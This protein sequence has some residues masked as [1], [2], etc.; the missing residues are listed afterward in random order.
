MEQKTLF[1][2]WAESA[3]EAAPGVG[4]KS[5]VGVKPVVGA[6][7][8]VETGVTAVPTKTAGATKAEPLTKPQILTK[9]QTSTKPGTGTVVEP[10]T[11]VE[12]ETA[13]GGETADDRDDRVAEISA[14]WP[15]EADDACVRLDPSVVLRATSRSFALRV[16]GDS[17]IGAGIQDGDLVV[18]EFTPEARPGQIVVALIDG[19]CALKRFVVRQGQPYLVSENPG[20]PNFVPLSELVI[21]GIVSTVVRPVR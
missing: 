8:A 21:Q 20:S 16:R 14:G 4:V 6:E 13:A 7:P 15:E 5:A 12:P 11:V 10:A 9:P 3:P 19:E 18:G 17:M 2:Q 1:S